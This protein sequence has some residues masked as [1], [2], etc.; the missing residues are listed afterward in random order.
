MTRVSLVQQVHQIA[1]DIFS[2]PL[3]AVT[4]QSSPNTIVTWD[5]LQHVNL[6]LALEQQFDVQ[7]LPE[8]IAEMS[9]IE[10]IVSLVEDK[11]AAS[12]ITG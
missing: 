6:V 7:F 2:V 5:S 12:A 1:A 11:I 10:L 4:A 9:R 8:E 3:E